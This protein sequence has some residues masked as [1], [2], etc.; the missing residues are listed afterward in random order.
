M[1]MIEPVSTAATYSPES[2]VPDLSR[3]NIDLRAA[4]DYQAAERPA[5][6][7]L[8]YDEITSV[9]TTKELLDL[10]QEK[11]VVFRD[12]SKFLRH[13]GRDWLV[14]CREEGKGIGDGVLKAPVP[15]LKVEVDGQQYGILGV[16]H[17]FML[18]SESI[19]AINKT[20]GGTE[21]WLHEQNL[22][23]IFKIPNS[24]ELKDH[25]VV[26]KQIEDNPILEQFAAGAQLGLG[27]LA[28]LVPGPNSPFELIPENETV[29]GER[30]GSIAIG[31]DVGPLSVLKKM[32]A[33]PEEIVA[34]SEL[35]SYV[36]IEYKMRH[37]LPLNHCQLRSA[38]M[39][40]MLRHWDVDGEKHVLCGRAH[41][42]EIAYFLKHPLPLNKIQDLAA[43]HS[44]I[45]NSKPG[46]K[47]PLA[48][49]A[50]WNGPIYAGK[51]VGTV[52][53]IYAVHVATQWL[54]Q[55]G[56]LSSIWHGLTPW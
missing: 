2:V 21:N 11:G 56:V 27:P 31:K 8:S 39:A 5:R 1:S 34:S 48:D 6:V 26:T 43:E 54:I 28:W 15:L 4:P 40:E 45:L 37:R 44:K 33:I 49:V 18:G 9:T 47:H 52:A 23:S 51:V 19:D 36:A 35:P 30:D 41:A 50:T 13:I 20:V 14:A 16:V 46:E 12:E 38:Y 22:G 10:Y 32:S 55:S 53:F 24:R 3:Y 25:R 7:R 29:D 17:T 42:A